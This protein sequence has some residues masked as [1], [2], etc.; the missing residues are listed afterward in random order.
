MIRVTIDVIPFGDET[1]RQTLE[2]IDIVNDCSGDTILGNY[3]FDAYGIETK[4]GIVKGFHRK[5]G[6]LELLRKTLKEASKL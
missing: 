6:A 4:S 5:F 1:R 2:T 3:R